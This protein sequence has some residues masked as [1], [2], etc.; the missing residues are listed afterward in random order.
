MVSSLPLLPDAS[1]QEQGLELSGAW[2]QGAPVVWG[3]A[4]FHPA[5]FHY[6]FANAVQGFK[7]SFNL[8]IVLG[9]SYKVTTKQMGVLIA[10][11]AQTT[12]S[13]SA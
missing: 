11:R 6:P 4:G 12:Q 1:S 13:L 7:H 9:A 8:A 2:R 5:F 10:L 3:P